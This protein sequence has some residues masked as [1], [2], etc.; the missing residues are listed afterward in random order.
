[1]SFFTLFCFVIAIANWNNQLQY[2]NKSIP[3][4]NFTCMPLIFL[5]YL[6]FIIQKPWCQGPM[7]Q[8]NYLCLQSFN[9][10]IFLIRF[11]GIL[12]LILL[13]RMRTTHFPQIFC[14]EFWIL[15]LA[16][17]TDKVCFFHQQNCKDSFF[18]NYWCICLFLK[19]MNQIIVLNLK[20]WILVIFR[21][22]LACVP[23]T[24]FMS[25][26]HSALYQAVST[27]SWKNTNFRVVF[28]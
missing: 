5:N 14:C 6:I 2:N 20:F 25:L 1:M 4:K 19:H 24:D 27:V 26:L 23:S 7:N 13:L 11:A 21:A 28:P 16:F 17:F 22:A 9:I 3:F 8:I 10:A 12:K 15:C 18:N